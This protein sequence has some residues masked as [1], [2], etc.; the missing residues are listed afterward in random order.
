MTFLPKL[1]RL[2]RSPITVEEL[3]KALQHHEFVFYYQPEWDLKTNRI[4]GVEALMRWESPKRGHVLPM[5]F[6]PLLEKSG[7]IHDFTNF[8]FQQTLA[9]LAKLHKIQPDLFMAVNLSICQLQEPKLIETIQKN[10]KLNKLDAK[11]LECELSESQELT[12]DILATNILQKLSGQGIAISIDDFG[13][14]YSSLARLEQ[15]RIQKLKIDLFFIRN[16]LK[17]KKNQAIVSSMI[18]LGHD[19]GFPVLA[20]GIETT[21][22]Q[23]WLKNNGCDYGQGYWLSHALPLADL[24][25]FLQKH[26]KKQKK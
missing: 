10:L 3:Q 8:L 2:I 12:E 1:L 18:K 21:A 26:T 17:D 14:G 23:K 4:I 13:T 22:Q 9:D 19:L 5:K 25:I 11:H 16:L 24:K 15:V 7:V 6:I 20:E